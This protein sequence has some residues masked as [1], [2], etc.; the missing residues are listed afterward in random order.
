MKKLF[1]L[2]L[3]W[4]GRSVYNRGVAIEGKSEV[5]YLAPRS[6][7]RRIKN[8]LDI[9]V[10]KYILGEDGRDYADIFSFF[11]FSLPLPSKGGYDEDGAKKNL[12]LLRIDKII[13][14]AGQV[15]FLFFSIKK[16]ALR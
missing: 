11:F 15:S 6:V 10:S 3:G 12:E 9:Y 5:F 8:P 16:I 4:F 1:N 14:S 13:D 2:L 7:W